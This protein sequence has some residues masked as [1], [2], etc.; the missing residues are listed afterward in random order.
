[1]SNIMRLA[2][3]VVVCVTIAG[4]TALEGIM[5]VSPVKKVLQRAMKS[6]N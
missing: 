5:L 2:W 1:M 4:G 3:V 6:H